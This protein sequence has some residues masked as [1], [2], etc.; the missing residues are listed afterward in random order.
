MKLTLTHLH[1]AARAVSIVMLLKGIGAGS[2]ALLAIFGF[3]APHFG[4]EPTVAQQGLVASLGAIG[5][6]VL[7][8]KG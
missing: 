4:I 8:L 1:H 6:A 2:L 3:A 7:A 5:G